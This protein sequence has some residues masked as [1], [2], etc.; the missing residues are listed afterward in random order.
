MVAL[1]PIS[2]YFGECDPNKDKEIRPVMEAIADAC[3]SSKTA[4]V[5]IIHNNKRGDADAI[6]KILG[7]VVHRRRQ[8]GGLGL[9]TG[10]GKEGR[11]LHEL[12][13]GQPRTQAHGHEVPDH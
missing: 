9:R 3:E 12:G 4:F 2:S 10:Q 6:G 13:Q 11:V 1:D 8:P 5:G 7:R